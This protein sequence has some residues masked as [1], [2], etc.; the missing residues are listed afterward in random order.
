LVLSDKNPSSF[1]FANFQNSSGWANGGVS[2]L[3]GLLSAVY[4]FLGL[5]LELLFDAF[6]MS[7]EFP[8]TTQL[9]IWRRSYLQPVETCP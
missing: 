7:I 5:V 1:V 8:G 2:W 9:A 6:M 3:V 4:P